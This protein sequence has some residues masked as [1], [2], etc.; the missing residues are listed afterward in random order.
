MICKSNCEVLEFGNQ[1]AYNTTLNLGNNLSKYNQTKKTKIYTYIYLYIDPPWIHF[2]NS[3][4]TQKG[5]WTIISI[6][7]YTNTWNMKLMI[8]QTNY[9]NM[10]SSFK[11]VISRNKICFL[12]KVKIRMPGSIPAAAALSNIPCL[13]LMMMRM[14]NVKRIVR[15]MKMKTMKMKMRMRIIKNGKR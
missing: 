13:V 5:I 10:I 3:F 7:I 15:I 8:F 6:Y 12:H 2:Q 11:L 1:K 4:A 14:M 9:L